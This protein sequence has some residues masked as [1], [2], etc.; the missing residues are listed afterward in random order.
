MT[1]Q[2][3]K[4]IRSHYKKHAKMYWFLYKFYQGDGF[5]PENPEADAAFEWF[6]TYLRVFAALV[7]CS[8]PRAADMLNIR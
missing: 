8:L 2:E 7:G 3:Y 5:N 1:K 6:H 4:K